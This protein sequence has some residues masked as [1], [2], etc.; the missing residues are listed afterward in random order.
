MNKTID[1]IIFYCQI[2]KD[3]FAE[4][5]DSKPLYPC[6][7][8]M[9]HTNS[10]SAERWAQGYYKG[11]DWFTVTMKNTFTDAYVLNTVSTRYRSAKVPQAIVYC[12]EK[13]CYLQFDFRS[14]A[15]V[16]TLLEGVIDHGKICQAMSFRFTAGNYYFV[17]QHGK[18]WQEFKE[19]FTVNNRPKTA[20]TTEVEIGVPFIGSFDQPHVYLGAYKCVQDDSYEEN[21]RDPGLKT[22]YTGKTVHLYH[23]CRTFGHRADDGANPPMAIN[24]SKM[25]VKSL[26]IPDDVNISTVD[27]NKVTRTNR[28]TKGSYGVGFYTDMWIDHDAKEIKI[29]EKVPVKNNTY[30]CWNWR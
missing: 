8:K 11:R 10:E 25:N 5:Y 9:L 2:P 19:A 6:W 28:I 30:N 27:G 4:I 20:K 7:P 12:E 17:P 3:Q 21:S 22:D 24:K 16:E 1:E 13:D 26:D 14:D 18:S 29:V 15:L 23:E